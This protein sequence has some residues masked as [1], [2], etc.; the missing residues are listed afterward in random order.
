MSHSA[1]DWVSQ[2]RRRGKRRDQ[3][4]SAIEQ[5]GL[6]GIQF[7]LDAVLVNG[8]AHLQSGLDGDRRLRPVDREPHD[9][10]AQ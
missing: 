2:A 1:P 6:V 4:R 7:D 8:A 9:S 3:R 5:V 10:T